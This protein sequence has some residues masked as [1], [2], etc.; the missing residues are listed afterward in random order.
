MH[1][2]ELNDDGTW[3]YRCQETGEV[4]SG[5]RLANGIPDR[6]GRHP[7]RS[8]APVGMTP[9]ELRSAA[10]ERRVTFGGRRRPSVMADAATARAV[11]I[12]RRPR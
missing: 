3:T 6:T 2:Y 7:A 1:H 10:F 8:T 12:Y 11:R 4:R 9:A 5:L